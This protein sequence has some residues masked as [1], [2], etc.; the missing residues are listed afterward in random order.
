M[1]QA[2]AERGSLATAGFIS[3]NN[4]LYIIGGMADFQAKADIRV[5]NEERG[6]LDIK[7]QM[8]TPRCY[9]QATT[10]GSKVVIWGGYAEIFNDAL[11]SVEVYDPLTNT[12][13]TLPPLDI[14][15]ANTGFIVSLGSDQLLAIESYPGHNTAFPFW[16]VRPSTRQVR[17][18]DKKSGTNAWLA[19]S[20]SSNS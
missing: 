13:E 14:F 7:A 15:T 6:T 18:Y 17:L 3:V 19:S 8:Q 4:H 2:E 11:A 12:L 9:P 10:W 16:R 5:L 20:N 1:G